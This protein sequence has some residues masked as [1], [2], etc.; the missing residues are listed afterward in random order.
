MLSDFV[1]ILCVIDHIA[2]QPFNKSLIIK[3]IVM[4]IYYN[5]EVNYDGLKK[6]L[7]ERRKEVVKNEI[8]SPLLK[9]LIDQVRI[10]KCRP[11]F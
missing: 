9:S 2:L 10:S 7:Q 1:S 5:S 3:V 8:I 6:K 11:R 4:Y